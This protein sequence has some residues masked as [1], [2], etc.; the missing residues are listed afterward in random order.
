MRREEFST[1]LSETL[2]E[3]QSRLSTKGNEYASDEQFHN[4][5]EGASR[6]GTT[7]EEY[8]LSLNT[9][10]EVSRDDLVR[11]LTGT[12]LKA[13]YYMAFEKI[14]DIL[15]YNILLLAMFYEHYKEGQEE[16]PF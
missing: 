10:H 16:L 11:K 3:I 9:K 8:L 7:K 14:H 6:R 1:F 5:I 15:A 2:S 12:F 4:F 13:D